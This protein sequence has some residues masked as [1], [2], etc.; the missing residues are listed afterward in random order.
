MATVNLLLAVQIM[1]RKRSTLG[2]VFAFFSNY[3]LQL[4]SPFQSE[5][6]V[7]KHVRQ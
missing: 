1:L 2:T 5:R 6:R 3:G 4:N 7:E